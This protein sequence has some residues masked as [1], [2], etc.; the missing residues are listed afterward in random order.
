MPLLSALMTCRPNVNCF[1]TLSTSFSL[2]LCLL[3]CGA[4]SLHGIFHSNPPSK[5]FVALNAPNIP[6]SYFLSVPAITPLKTKDWTVPISQA[7][8]KK[9]HP[10]IFLT[11]QCTDVKPRVASNITCLHTQL[12]AYENPFLLSL[13]GPFQFPSRRRSSEAA[14]CAALEKTS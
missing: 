8:L 10:Q 11:Q 5:V 14:F 7:L 1:I 9:H 12:L 2:F 4:E 3:F 13:L 6:L